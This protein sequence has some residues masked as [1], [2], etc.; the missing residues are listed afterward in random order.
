MH[1]YGIKS[2][3]DH[4]RKE[5]KLTTKELAKMLGICT[6]TVIDWHRA[7]LLNGRVANDKGDHLFDFPKGNLPSK[8]P[9]E[10][11]LVQQR[12]ECYS[13][14]SNILAQEYTLQQETARL[15]SP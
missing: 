7:G 8:R 14:L 12:A 5:G 13:S 2:Y 10:K 4:L 6:S 9:G 15:A 11:G 1:T 3:Y